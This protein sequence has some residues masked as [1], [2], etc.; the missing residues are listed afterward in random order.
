MSKQ[1]SRAQRVGDQIQR[2]LAVL[3]PREVKDPRLGFVTLTGVDVSRD[4]GHAKVYITLMNSDD[5]ETIDCNLEVL[6]ETAGYLRMLLGK[7]IRV[8][9]IPQLH[10]YYDESVSRGAYLSSLIERAVA[11]DRNHH[12][13]DEDSQ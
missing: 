12:Q 10:F 4:L 13:T 11:S 6:N 3:I 9:S 1:Y 7:A 8:R 2:E 5:A